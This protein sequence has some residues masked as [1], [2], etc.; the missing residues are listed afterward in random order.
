[1]QLILTHYDISKIEGM[2]LQRGMNFRPNGKNYSIF[3]MSVRDG[4][5]YNDMFEVDGKRLIYEGENVSATEKVDPKNFDQPLFTKTGN[6]SN[7][8]KFYQAAEDY[9]LSRRQN[10]EKIRVYEKITNNVWYDKGWFQLVDAEYKY[11]DLEKR[12]VFKFILLPLEGPQT[13]KE[14]SEQFE[15]SRRIPTEVKRIVWERDDAKCSHDGCGNKVNLH[16]DHIIP[17]SKGGSSTDPK[18]IQILCGKHNLSKSAKI[19]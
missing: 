8:G 15:F 18:N 11:S 7:N 16:F 13:S 14:E 9:K 10:A 5:P 6:L 2:S 3:L 12:K 17:W 19:I 4:S 1:M